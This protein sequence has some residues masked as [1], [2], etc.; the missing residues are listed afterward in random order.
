MQTAAMK[1]IVDCSFDKAPDR[2]AVDAA[3]RELDLER[4]SAERARVVAMAMSDVH[5]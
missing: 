2:V 4:F 5:G 1:R 3:R